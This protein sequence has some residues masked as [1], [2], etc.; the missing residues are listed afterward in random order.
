MC[1]QTTWKRPM[2]ARKNMTVYKLVEITN[3]IILSPYK[4]FI[5]ELNKTY[6]A[7]MEEV[8]DNYSYFD[9]LAGD[10]LDK[11]KSKGILFISIGSGFH[12]ATKKERLERLLFDEAVIM[13]AIIPKGA[14]YYK[15]I[16]DLIV[17][18]KIKLIGKA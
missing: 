8:D 4:Y 10:E 3:R 17:S 2:T 13:K 9:R 7:D 14:K 5:Y 11:L 12:S 15:G 16:S 6:S 18:N 1:L